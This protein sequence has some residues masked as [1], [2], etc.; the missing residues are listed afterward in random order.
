MSPAR[1]RNQFLQALCAAAGR[2]LIIAHRGDSA[3]APENTLEA[4]RLGRAK[5]ADAWELDVQL[6]RDGIPVVLH[7][8]SLLRTTDLATRYAGDPRIECGGYLADFDLAEIQML[9]A[10]SWFVPGGSSLNRIPTLRDALSLTVEL[11]WLVNVELKTFPDPNPRLL[12]AVFADLAATGTAER[13]LISSFNHDDVALAAIQGQGIAT[14]VLIASPLR[15]PGR[16][17]RDLVRA[18][19]LHVSTEVLGVQ[20]SAY[21]NL[22]SP[23]S[24]RRNLVQE[25]RDQTIP[26]L[27]YTINALSPSGLAADMARLGVSGLFCD[28][29]GGV[30]KVLSETR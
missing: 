20:T 15:S 23:A 27:V 14:G 26:L 25:L 21:G 9:D 4:A 11:D 17:V 10:G 5:R 6:T 2:P 3:H 13:V 19:C 30:R 1:S 18:D 8:E 12:D 7:D 24:L 22:P 29:P 16:Y 28:D